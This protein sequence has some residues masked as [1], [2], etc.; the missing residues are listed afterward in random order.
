M[1]SA[2]NA[3]YFC[4]ECRSVKTP[5]TVRVIGSSPVVASR[6]KTSLATQSWSLLPTAGKGCWA[7]MLLTGTATLTLVNGESVSLTAPAL[8]W[9]PNRLGALYTLDAGG[10]GYEFSVTDDFVWRT[11]GDS[12]A[13]SG[14]KLLMEDVTVAIGDSIPVDE[15]ASSFSAVVREMA[16]AAPGG[17]SIVGFHLGLVLL[18]V[19]RAL[20][21]MEANTAAM[22]GGA[23]LVHRFR[24]LVET[25]FREGLRLDD[26]AQ[27]L[28]V[29]RSRLH[30]ACA[31]LEGTTPMAIIHSRLLEEAQRRL[32]QTEMSVEQ[33]AY[34]LGFR[35]AGYF[36]R[37]FT[38]LAGA[39]PGA[40]RKTM[41]RPAGHS[42]ASSFAAWP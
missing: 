26:Y 21:A 1:Y 39:N 25:H 11:I 42:D 18:H 4:W 3:L 34:S 19:W 23:A 22:T 29:T 6:M 32:I 24:Q 38:R 7:F 20:G 8:A 35:D 40:F 5:G 12:S 37:F 10:S 15:V 27:R 31:R 30:D 14:L 41:R 33:V 16:I 13:A 36:N 9:I 28:S 17:A 2:R